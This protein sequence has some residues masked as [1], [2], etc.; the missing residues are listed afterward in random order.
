MY[1][2][3]TT[4]AGGPSG[5]YG[6]AIGYRLS[7]PGQLPKNGGCDPCKG[8]VGTIDPID[9]GTGNVSSS[10]T[11]FVSGDGRLRLDRYY[12]SNLLNPN[13]QGTGWQNSFAA[14]H[15]SDITSGIGAVKPTNS[16]VYVGNQLSNQYSSPADAC[17]QGL[18]DLAAQNAAYAGLTATYIGNDQC[19][20]SNGVII[21]VITNGVMAFE[22]SDVFINFELMVFRA[23][24]GYV[25]FSCTKTACNDTD[26]SGYALIV[27]ASGYTLTVTN[28]DVEYYDQT[29]ALIEVVSRDGY[30]QS[31]SYNTD[32][33]V[34]SVVDNHNREMDFLYT[35]GLLTSVNLPDGTSVSYGYNSNAQLTTVTYADNSVVQYQY[36]DTSYPKAMTAEVDETNAT[37][38]TW[39]YDDSSGFATFNGLAGATAGTYVATDTLQYN[40]GYTVHT[41]SL[42]T[43]RTYN[44]QDLS[45]ASRLVSISGPVCMRCSGNAMTYDANGYLASV[46]DWNNNE[47]DYTFDAAGLLDTLVEGKGT[48]VQRTTQTT[49][50]T[51]HR[52]PT[53]RTVSDANNTVVSQTAW[54][55][56]GRG[57]VLARCEVDPQVSYTCS[58]AGTVPAGVRRWT[59]SYCDAVDTTQCPLVGLLLSVTGPRTDIT[60]TTTYS[61]YLTSSA[62]NCGTPGGACYQVGDLYQVTDPLGHVTTVASY[63]GAGRVTRLT[64][65]NGVNTDLT[66]TPRGWLHTR[67]VGGATTTI[68]YTPYGAVHTITDPDGYVTTYGYDNAHRLTDIF[69][70]QNN[71]LHYSLNA[72]GEKTGE[73][74]AT[75]SG[76]QTKSLTRNYNAL[77]QLTSIVDGLNAT[78]FHADYSDSYDANGN[79]THTADALGI[80]REQGYDALN[81]LKSTLDNY[82]GTDTATQ[83]TLTSVTQDALDR[84]TSVTDPDNLATQYTY[85]GLGNLTVLQSPDSGTSGGST[86]DLHDAA[87]NLN[88]HTDA[89]GVVTQYTY[90]ALNRLTGKIYPAHPGLNVAYTYDQASPINGCPNN[91]NIGHLTGMTDASGTTAWCYTNQGDIREVR[92]VI[93]TVA[94]LHGYAYTAGRR[95]QYLQYPSGFE[96]KYG[97]DTDGRVSTIGYL[98]Q[99]GPFGNYTNS[100]LTPLITAVTYEPFGPVTGYSWAQGGQYVQRLYDKNY[101]LTDIVSN[102]N[103]ALTGGAGSGGLQLHFQRD[104]EGRIGTEGT[105]A[106][107]N[108]PSESYQYDPLN[109]LKELDDANG[110]LEQGYTYDRTGDRLSKTLAGQSPVAYGYQAGSHRL[111]AVGSTVRTPDANGN[112]TALTDPRGDVVGLGYDD[113]N[114]LTTVTR[115]GSVIGTYQYNGQ[116]VRVWRTITSPSA[117][118][119]AT[120]Y[121]PTGTGNL[122]G[123]YFAADYREYVYLDGIPVA[124][125]TDAG[126]AAPGITYLFADQLGTV[127]AVSNPQGVGSYQWAWLDNPFG[128]QPTTG[129]SSLYTRFP[130]Q[131]YDVETGLHYNGARYYDPGT[132]RYLQSD[133]IGLVG[134]VS[135]Y[136]YVGNNPFSYVDPWGLNYAQSWA[137]GGAAIGGAFTAGASV[138]AD[139]YTGGTNL[140]A[141]GPEIAGGSAVG[142]GLG[143]VFGSALD[144]LTQQSSGYTDTPGNKTPW[145]GAPGSTVRGGTGSRTYGEDGYPATDRDWPHPDEGPPGND[146]HCHD[147]GRPP[148]GGP[149]SSGDRGPPRPPEPGDPPP[150]RGPNVPPPEN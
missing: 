5:I 100:T 108:P 85:D 94:Y 54:Q 121:D 49:W 134:G 88:Q 144:W 19:Q 16:L 26:H 131:Y 3:G 42:G 29:G 149:P 114:L 13:G 113:R 130:G 25:R 89:R 101:A 103:Y 76:T 87:G 127:R 58:N 136:A 55:L 79:V 99:A 41:D 111:T 104:I 122:Y 124:A 133:P 35:N 68:G 96:L 9:M 59:Y 93:N 39:Q 117:G 148:N 75:A 135:T 70:A 142:G 92:Q 45:G 147:W 44:Y 132:G 69:D 126:R 37:Y 34:K 38:A 10:A 72:A 2:H 28:G 63:D 84:V 43:A 125:A 50:D 74:I 56:N 140:P 61:Y 11:D 46:K 52:V 128:E 48:P 15:I 14:R 17:T 119:A 83:N 116:G 90:D 106:G 36:T 32:G 24:G 40:V 66:Y 73:T 146:D 145:T 33:T 138:V 143:Y 129:T 107:A 20:L 97:F 6:T 139:V 65:A 8:Q 118:Q 137:I 51:V 67:S 4:C 112:T 27:T 53:A 1:V 7:V 31:L 60:Q 21:P 120:V 102:R 110:N 12:N 80:Q 71:D 95:L 150:P 115:A 82:N 91:F 109:R 18:A 30:T 123:E 81:R 57:Q 47:T 78:I 77:G 98:Q 105:A 23:E 86:G 141:T 22:P 62:T 64:D